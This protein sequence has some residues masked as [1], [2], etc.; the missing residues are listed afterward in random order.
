MDILA[1]MAVAIVFCALGFFVLQNR[2]KRPQVTQEKTSPRPVS[3]PVVPKASV[4]SV[5]QERKA[6]SFAV[7]DLE[8]TGLDPENDRIIEICVFI[9][10]TGTLTHDGHS[11]LVNP[12]RPLS[13]FITKLTGITDEM[14]E[15][16][17]H[18]ECLHKYFDIIGERT[19]FAYNADFDMGF[20]K[21]A[22]GRM[23]R[24][25]ENPRRCIMELVKEHHPNL[26]SYKLTEVCDA[27]NIKPDGVAHRAEYDCR[28]AFLVTCAVSSGAQ[29][30][31]SAVRRYSNDYGVYLH[32]RKDNIPFY[33]WT[34]RDGTST[35][36]DGD[37]IW[38]FY[39]EKKLAND[40]EIR[41]VRDGLSLDE[42]KSMKSNLMAKHAKT[43]LNRNNVA[44]GVITKNMDRRDTL[45]A[46]SFH[47][48]DEAKALE[49]TAPNDAIDLYLKALAIIEEYPKIVTE[50]GLFGE[51][52]IEYR[53]T[54]H[55]SDAVKVLDRTS[56][57]MCRQGN[58]HD[59]EDI[60]QSF[61][62]R[63]ETARSASGVE[64]ILRRI[65]KA[66]KKAPRIGATN[67]SLHTSS[68]G[69]ETH[70]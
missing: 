61:F 24:K 26:M 7:V 41:C 57:I 45:K 54:S 16:A 51:I 29:P 1:T 62:S 69:T 44:R 17:D 14:L 22:A 27:F 52:S 64:A 8:T 2:R 55:S 60:V 31:E 36:P 21:A 15:G 68:I 13:L 70:I 5:P 10:N 67:A 35:K 33:V 59:A 6:E 37:P 48:M 11:T 19:V 18:E 38:S 30:K 40:Y 9:I 49:T 28:S 34:A 20:L 66:K 63:Y 58:P 4:P 25:F 56:L 3:P 39:A 12:G 65:E 47:L 32:Y 23:G 43:V 53:A 50:K 46:S 42:A